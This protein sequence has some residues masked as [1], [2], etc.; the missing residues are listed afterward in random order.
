MSK[1]SSR[2]EHLPCFHLVKIKY[3]KHIVNEE[4]WSARLKGVK[5]AHKL[6]S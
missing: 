4:V 2:P 1:C 5:Y 6:C 3:K